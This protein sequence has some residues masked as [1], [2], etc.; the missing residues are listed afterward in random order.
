M[1]TEQGCGRARLHG[2]RDEEFER[3]VVD[4]PVS[5]ASGGGLGGR[6]KGDGGAWNVWTSRCKEC[7]GAGARSVVAGSR[8]GAGSFDVVRTTEVK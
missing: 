8:D 2:G 6:R 4:A 5:A 7:L 3:S 1:G